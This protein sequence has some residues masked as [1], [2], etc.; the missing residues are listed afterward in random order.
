MIGRVAEGDTILRLAQRLDSALAGQELAVSAP[1]P[2]GRAAGVERLDGRQFEAA[3]ARGKHLLLHF[4]GL[5]LHSHLGMSG[6]WHVYPRGGPW[7]RPRSSAWAVLS[8][9]D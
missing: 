7:R 9:R 3:D 4:G 1:N 5:V 8:G 6:G 2:R